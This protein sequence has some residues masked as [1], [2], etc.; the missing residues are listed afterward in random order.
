MPRI[1]DLSTLVATSVSML[2]VRLIVCIHAVPS[3]NRR[4]MAGA[5]TAVPVGPRRVVLELLRRHELVGRRGIERFVDSTT[6]RTTG[7]GPAS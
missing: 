3:E 4:R 1:E 7:G 5:G 6:G 2:A